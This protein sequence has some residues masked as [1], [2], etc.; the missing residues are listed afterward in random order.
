M[1]AID[2]GTADLRLSRNG[3][4]GNPFDGGNLAA[5]RIVDVAVPVGPYREDAD[6]DRTPLGSGDPEFR[7]PPISDRAYVLGFGRLGA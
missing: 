1:E 4:A 2:V 6:V 7:C 5:D 3:T